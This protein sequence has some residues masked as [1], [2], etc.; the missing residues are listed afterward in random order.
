M[1]TS[2]TSVGEG[3]LQ[4]AILRLKSYKEMS[5]KA[6]AQLSQEQLYWMPQTGSNSVAVIMQHMAGNMLSRWTNFLTEDGEKSWRDRDQE[7]LKPEGDAEQLIK[8]L[9]TAWDC[10]FRALQQ[11]QACDLLKSITIRGE[12]IQVFDAILRQ[13]MHYSSHVGQIIYLAKM[14]KAE[15]WHPLTIASGQS[16]NYNKKMGYQP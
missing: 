9:E 15:D 5:D 13:L 11:L 1:V 14:M 10:L 8:S 2:F 4:Q 3:L 16:K 7:F 6:I 12:Q